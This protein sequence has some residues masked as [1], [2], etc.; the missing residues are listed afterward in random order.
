MKIKINEIIIDPAVAIREGTDEETIQRYEDNLDQLPPIVVYHTDHK[1]LLADGFHRW[2]AATRKGWEYIK[3]E[4][5]EGTYEE[6]SEYAIYA[7]LKHGKPLTREEYK[8]AVRRLSNLH[9]NWGQQKLANAIMRSDQFVKTI[10]KSDEVRRSGIMIPLPDRLLEQISY[11]PKVFQK[12][13]AERAKE[14]GWTT[15]TIA[16]KVREIKAEPERVEEILAPIPEEMFKEPELSP[17]PADQIV[18]LTN[19]IRKLCDMLE[20]S[21]YDWEKG[22]FLKS[23]VLQGLYVLADKTTKMIQYLEGK[24]S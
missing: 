2:A 13:L 11:A 24:A 15:Q 12:S 10:I 17:T 3:A 9:P 21:L 8:N 18:P 23:H 6:A 1:Y 19:E 7:N 4:V 20:P 5:R 14:A 22:R 16:E